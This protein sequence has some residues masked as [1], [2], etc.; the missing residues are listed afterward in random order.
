M[1]TRERTSVAK[2]IAETTRMW[3]R[4]HMRSGTVAQE[5]GSGDDSILHSRLAATATTN[6]GRTKSQ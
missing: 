3:V 6:D 5:R 2:V 1:H 4:F